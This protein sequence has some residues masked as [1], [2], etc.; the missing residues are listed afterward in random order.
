MGCVSRP[1]AA[2]THVEGRWAWVRGWGRGHAVGRAGSQP[3]VP[4][5]PATARPLPAA[6]GWNTEKRRLRKLPQEELVDLDVF[7]HSG[8]D[9]A[10][11]V[12]LGGVRE[13]ATLRGTVVAQIWHHGAQVRRGAAAGVERGVW[14]G[15]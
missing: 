1:G 13:G 4:H 10:G 2:G 5:P 8:E 3:R 12:P 15:V 14:R 11:R 6:D 7:A 9:A